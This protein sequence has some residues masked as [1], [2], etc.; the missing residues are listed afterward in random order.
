MSKSNK[1]TGNEKNQYLLV[2]LLLLTLIASSPLE[3]SM[4]QRHVM[5]EID[6]TQ[7]DRTYVSSVGLMDLDLAMGRARGRMLVLEVESIKQRSFEQG[8]KI[9]PGHTLHTHCIV[10]IRIRSSRFSPTGDRTGVRARALA[11]T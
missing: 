1:N 3:I 9:L 5:S 4:L 11:H 6:A 7:R 2:L 8:N 10:I